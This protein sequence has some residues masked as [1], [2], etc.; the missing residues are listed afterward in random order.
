[1][2]LWYCNGLVSSF[3]VSSKG[4]N[5]LVLNCSLLKVENMWVEVV[6]LIVFLSIVL[7]YRLMFVSCVMVVICMVGMRLLDC[8]IFMV[9]MLVFVEQVNLNVFSGLCSVLL[10][11]I[12][13]VNW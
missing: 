5:N 4:L 12:G 2:K 7:L 6:V 3:C 13:M 1:M 8:V 9:K 11:I 10:V